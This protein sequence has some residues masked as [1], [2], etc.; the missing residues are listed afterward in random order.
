MRKHKSSR[1]SERRLEPPWRD[2]QTGAKAGLDVC[3]TTTAK[4]SRWCQQKYRVYRALAASRAR[5]EVRSSLY[6]ALFK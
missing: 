6:L 4:S 3:K 2:A 5:R 1:Q